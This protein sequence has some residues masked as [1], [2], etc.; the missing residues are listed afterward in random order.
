[1]RVLDIRQQQFLVLLF[2][3]EAQHQ[4]WLD[5]SALTLKSF[6]EKLCDAR[7]D[8][9][10]VFKDFTQRGSLQQPALAAGNPLTHLVVVGVEQ[11]A[12]LRMVRLVA[13]QERLKE[14]GLE[15]PAGVRQVP[16]GRAGLGH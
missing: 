6:L 14:E 11:K 3:M 13:R 2:V 4:A 16:F 7:V 12:E 15:K 10:A 1:E 9:S 5:F 8:P